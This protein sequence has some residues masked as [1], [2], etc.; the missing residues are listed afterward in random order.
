VGNAVKALTPGPGEPWYAPYVDTTLTPQFHFEDPGDNPSDQVVLGFVVASDKGTCEPSWGTH[1]SLD[2]AA[3][4]L[5]LDRRIARLRQRSTG[6]Q[7]GDVI[8]SFGG[9]INNELALRCDSV[10]ALV[11]AY[12]AVIERYQLTTIDFDI[13]GAALANG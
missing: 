6:G 4:K 5:D 10:D 13:E 2:E 1:F 9:A 8:V 3:T 7:T 11:S 12:S